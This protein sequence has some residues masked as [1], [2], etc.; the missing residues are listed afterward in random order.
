MCTSVEKKDDESS[1]PLTSSIFPLSK[2][3][4][5]ADELVQDC[6]GCGE[7]FENMKNILSSGKHHCRKW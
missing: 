5:Q 7:S 6:S 1:N 4:W 2:T 3:E